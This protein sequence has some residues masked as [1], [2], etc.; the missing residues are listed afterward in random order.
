MKL[1][2]TKKEKEDEEGIEVSHRCEDNNAQ[3]K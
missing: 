2:T 1:E 3:K